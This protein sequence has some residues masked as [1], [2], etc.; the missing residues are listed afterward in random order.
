MIVDFFVEK[1]ESAGSQQAIA[2]ATGVA[3]YTNIFQAFEK[4]QEWLEKQGIA[5][6]KVV[7]FAGDYNLEAIS[8]FL[9][10]AKNQNIIVPLSR[11]SQAHFEEFRETAETEFDISL[12]SSNPTVAS[13]GENHHIRYTRNCTRG[14]H[15]VSYFFHQAQ[16]VKA[17]ESC[18]I[19]LC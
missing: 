5:P 17:K 19:S 15:L 10:L 18:R 4:W 14:K 13:T 1:I 6:G 8:L 9:A 12:S 11:D 3:T 2:D 16:P 7:S